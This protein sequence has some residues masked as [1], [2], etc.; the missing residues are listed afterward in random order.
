MMPVEVPSPL[1]T[2]PV[3]I[4]ALEHVFGSGERA[5][6][7]LRGVDLELGLGQLVMLSGPSGCGKTTLLSILTG[8][9]TPTR[10]RVEVFG[11]SWSELSTEA[12]T[13]RRGQ[14]IGYLFQRHHLIPT[15]PVLE[16]VC[17]PLLVRGVR[18]AEAERRAREE[19]A[20]VWLESRCQAMPAELSGGMQQRVALAR[21]LIGQPRLVVCDEPTASL[22][23]ESGRVVMELLQ[24]CSRERDDAGQARCV[25]VVTHDYRALCYADLIFQMEDGQLR[26]ANA[27]FL[28]RVWQSALTFHSPLATPSLEPE[29]R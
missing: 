4:Q 11:V 25:F 2:S 8:L 5:V 19:L 24:A 22:D 3:R 15:L 9:L 20:K 23:S 16:N 13:V 10:G 17:L 6:R 29:N 21:A 14:M 7:A 18:R 27:D 1:E 12:K 26:P 28:V